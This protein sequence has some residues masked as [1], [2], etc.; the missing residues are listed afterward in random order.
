MKERHFDPRNNP[1]IRRNMHMI[2]MDGPGQ[3]MSNIR[4][5][6]VTHDNYE[7]AAS[8]VIDYLLTRPEVDPGGIVMFGNSMGSFWAIHTAASDSR[9]KAVA[10][11]ASCFGAK[12]AIFEQ[13]SP[14]FKQVFMYMAGYD[15]EEAFDRDVAAYPA[16]GFGCPPGPNRQRRFSEHPALLTLSRSSSAC[17]RATSECPH[18]SWLGKAH[19]QWCNGRLSTK[20]IDFIE[21]GPR[22]LWQAMRG[23]PRP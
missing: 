5:I 21:S 2:A 20:P 22:T 4:K 3:G 23:R 9:I 13:S 11:G 15:K 1:V 6:R 18:C 7:R 12:T 16:P 10:T 14:R 17:R 19:H 8:A